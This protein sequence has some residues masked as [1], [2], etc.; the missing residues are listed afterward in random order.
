MRFRDL[1]NLA[2]EA[3]RRHRLR[4]A[5][6]LTGIAVG[7]AAVLVL[8]A[9]GEGARQYVVREFVGMGTNIVA[10]LPGK[11]ETTGMIGVF[12]GTTRDLTV[13]DAIAL[14]RRCAAVWR[15]A[16][17]SLGE[18]PVE[19]GASGRTVPVMGTTADYLRIRDFK[20]AAGRTLPDD[21][22]RGERVCV[23]GTT[24]RHSLFGDANPLGATVR[25]GEWRFRV[26]GLLEAKGR[27]MGI[28]VDDIVLVPVNS[29]MR[30]FNRTSLFRILVQARSPM[31]VD[32]AAGEV[33]VV[34]QERHDGEEDFTVITAGAM[35][36]AFDSVLGALTAA[37]AAI[38]GISLLVAGIGIM[39]V[40]LVSVSERTGEI[41]L[42]KAIGARRRDILGMFLAEA[43]TLSLAGAAIGVGL[44]LAVLTGV[45]LAFPD[46][47]PRLQ[48]VWLAAAVCVALVVG[49][50][51]GVVP[52]RRAANVEAAQALAGRA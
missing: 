8:T 1:A 16:P 36:N 29:G 46:L 28:D 17:V 12:G 30:M 42:L 24:V 20:I 25:I 51:F 9:L 6:S 15:A 34:L 2:S 40:M 11:V 19:F 49:M 13:D 10:V 14:P 45:A 18:A 22:H 52:A 3:P 27:M 33:K 39:N 38:A 7:V 47:P 48:P 31:E 37:V 44:S 32:R 5:L 21:P 35:V 41:G 50:A 26:I 4:S 43:A 23:I